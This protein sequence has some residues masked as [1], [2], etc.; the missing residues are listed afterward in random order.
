MEADGSSEF[1]SAWKLALMEKFV[2]G[3]SI[4][5]KQICNLLKCEHFRKAPG[6]MQLLIVRRI[7]PCLRIFYQF[8]TLIN[9]VEGHHKPTLRELLPQLTWILECLSEALLFDLSHRA[10]LYI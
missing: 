7:N 2:R 4:Y 8:R 1:S 3:V 10:F 6:I 5:P 9:G